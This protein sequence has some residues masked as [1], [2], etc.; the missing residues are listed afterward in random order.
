MIVSRM[1]VLFK[2]LLQNILYHEG[3]NGWLSKTYWIIFCGKFIS[4]RL[5]GSTQ[6]Q[7]RCIQP[8]SCWH[9][10]HQMQ[11]WVHVSEIWSIYFNLKACSMS[12]GWSCLVRQTQIIYS[13]TKIQISLRITSSPIPIGAKKPQKHEK[14]LKNLK[15]NEFLIL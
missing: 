7:I 6:N 11:I 14:L 10:Q 12:H 13:I 5:Q 3:T 9:T 4:Q 15:R 2:F 8:Q 1:F